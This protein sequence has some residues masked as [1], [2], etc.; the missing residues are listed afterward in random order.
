MEVA[1]EVHRGALDGQKLAENGLLTGIQRTG[2]GGEGRRQLGV[3]GLACQLLGPELGQVEVAAAVVE[4][5]GLAL[6]GLVLQQEGA[7]GPVQRV[8][9]DLCTGVARGRGQ[10]LEADREGQ[11]LAQAVPA[12]V[13][14]LQQLLDVL[15]SGSARA[16]TPSR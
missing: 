6:R 3:V 16:R 5:A 14:F 8:G 7:G 10:V 1:A 12:Q 4:L 9:K 11:E 15:R 2:D 13:V